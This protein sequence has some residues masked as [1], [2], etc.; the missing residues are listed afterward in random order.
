IRLVE[1]GVFWWN[2][3][4]G[5]PYVPI[6]VGAALSPDVITAV[7]K[8]QPA[9]I[10][11]PQVVDTAEPC[12]K[13][14]SAN[15]VKRLVIQRSSRAELFPGEAAKRRVLESV[16]VSAIAAVAES[17]GKGV[18]APGCIISVS[19]GMSGRIDLRGY[20]TVEVVSALR[21]I[22]VAPDAA[23]LVTLPLNQRPA[24]R[25]VGVNVSSRGIGSRL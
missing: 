18:G 1:R 22:G 2:P 6:V 24:K 13:E 12:I 7:V 23:G 15:V 16:G 17:T 19:D 25:V 3:R 11:V 4:L 5:K 9:A 20:M 10:P 14:L 8:N 21:L